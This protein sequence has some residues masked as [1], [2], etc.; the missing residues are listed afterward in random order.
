MAT[1]TLTNT[2]TIL[3]LA[4]SVTGWQGDTFAFQSD[5]FLQG[6]G[7]VECSLTTNGNNGVLVESDA[8]KQ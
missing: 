8:I 3:N 7:A 6:S 5:L 1:A 2:P 4:E